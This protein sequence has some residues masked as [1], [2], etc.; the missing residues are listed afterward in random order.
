[1]TLVWPLLLLWPWPWSDDLDIRT[2]RRCSKDVPTYQKSK[3]LRQGSQTASTGETDRQTDRTHYQLHVKQIISKLATSY[4][5]FWNWCG[6]FP[7]T[8][9][10]GV[11]IWK[12]RVSVGSWDRHIH[13][14][15][16]LT[17]TV[18]ICPVQDCWQSLHS[19]QSHVCNSVIVTNNQMNVDNKHVITVNSQPSSSCDM[20]W[21]GL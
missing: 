20:I 9:Q 5:Q 19:T 15:S 10:D 4:W 14:A 7:C 21:C 17:V 16:W 11:Q 6:P 1:M 8:S 2:W 18:Q 13:T 3:F 12:Q